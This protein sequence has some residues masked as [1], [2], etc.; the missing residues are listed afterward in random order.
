MKGVRAA[1]E[2]RAARWRALY[3]NLADTL[4]RA[5][6]EDAFG[7]GDYW[8]VDDDWGN[9]AAKVI[10]TS[11]PMLERDLI[12]DIQSLLRRVS[13]EWYVVVQLEL[14]GY[15]HSDP[16]GVIV[17]ANRVEESWNKAELAATL[18]S[19]IAWCAGVDV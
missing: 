1:E 3:R 7:R 9:T 8:I 12:P 14:S 19:E 5:G 18:G 13:H 16:K 11:P 2:D 10:I 17:Y 15:G 4:A 6:T